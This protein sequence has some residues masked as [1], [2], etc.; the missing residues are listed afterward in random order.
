MNLTELWLG[1]NKITKLEGMS[2]LRKL[3]I[4]SIQSNRI[5]KLEGLDEL[6]S[7]EEVYVSHNGIKRLEGL[8]HNV[9]AGE[10][11][12]ACQTD[13]VCSTNYGFWISA[14]ITFPTSRT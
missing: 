8:S 3:K 1:K 5:L 9:R 7:L 14:T 13:G 6:E 4:L 11:A 12:W 2:T 10:S